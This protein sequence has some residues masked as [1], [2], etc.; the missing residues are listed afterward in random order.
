M[1]KRVWHDILRRLHTWTLA[2]GVEGRVLAAVVPVVPGR[3]R[4]V[5]RRVGEIQVQVDYGELLCG[6]SEVTRVACG[7]LGVG[8]QIKD[9]PMD[10]LECKREEVATSVGLKLHHPGEGE[11]GRGTTEF[12]GDALVEVAGCLR[13]RLGLVRAERRYSGDGESQNESNAR[14][15]LSI[16]PR[17]RNVSLTLHTAQR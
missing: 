2:V 16:V 15:M 7:N 9:R 17:P 6:D 12:G 8:I 14:G 13:K 1:F 11:I 5:H 4:G 10:V 3:V